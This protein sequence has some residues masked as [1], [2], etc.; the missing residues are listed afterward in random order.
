MDLIR[1]LHMG[2]NDS[3]CSHGLRIFIWPVS[4]H[5]QTIGDEGLDITERVHSPSKMTTVVN[6]KILTGSSKD[7]IQLVPTQGKY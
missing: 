4:H 2:W 1:W 7:E 3:L 6:Q 5:Y